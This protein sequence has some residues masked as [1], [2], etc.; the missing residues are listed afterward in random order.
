VK[1][2]VAL[3]G[4]ALVPFVVHSE[5]RVIEVIVADGHLRPAFYEV[6]PT[7]L[8]M[9]MA[10]A[11]QLECVA[12]KKGKPSALDEAELKS[13]APWLCSG[14]P[15]YFLRGVRADGGENEDGVACAGD[16]A[17]KYYAADIVTDDE[18][19]VAVY[20]D[21]DRKVHSLQ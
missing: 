12:H 3:L 8:A 5:Q 17:Y 6:A 4:V 10:A 20:Y 2:S 14:D 21:T 7:Y 16:P 15:L 1:P 13:A 11:V 9:S 19:C 18:S